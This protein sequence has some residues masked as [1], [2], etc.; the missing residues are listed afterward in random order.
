MEKKE[1]MPS[2]FKEKELLETYKEMSK[3][4]EELSVYYEKKIAK[5][6]AQQAKSAASF[7]SWLKSGVKRAIHKMY[8]ALIKGLA[9][10]KLKE[11]LKKTFIYKMLRGKL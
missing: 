9:K 8:T 1:Q 11:P 2:A 6:Q 10:T 7:L 4:V 3:F 5:I